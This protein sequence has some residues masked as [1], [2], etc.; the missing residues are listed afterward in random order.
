MKEIYVIESITGGYWDGTSRFRGWLFAEK[1]DYKKGHTIE[2]N[3]K[4]AIK[5]SPCKI[6]TIYYE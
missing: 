1:Y 4:L 6:T 5:S 2:R 3:L